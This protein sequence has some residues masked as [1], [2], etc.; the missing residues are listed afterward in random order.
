MNSNDPNFNRNANF[1]IQE[2][3]FKNALDNVT[4]IIETEKNK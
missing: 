3:V 4:L 2:K 1:T